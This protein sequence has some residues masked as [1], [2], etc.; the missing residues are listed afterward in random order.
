MGA[1]LLVSNALG[2]G[3]G[4][5]GRTEIWA[6]VIG[7]AGNPLI[8]TGFESFWIS[9]NVQKVWRS[10]SG[11]WDPKGLNEAHNGYLEV[12]LNLG[13]IG[14]CLIALI[15]FSGYR[16]A[17]EAFGRDPEFGGL[18]LAYVATATFYSITEAGFRS[19]SPSWFFFLLAV[20]SASGIGA[21]LF[22]GEARDDFGSRGGIAVRKSLSN[23]VTPEKATVS[24]AQRGLARFRVAHEYSLR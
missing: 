1:D 11:W 14:V 3:E 10:L 5:S 20:I 13:W 21:G 16:R 9:P 24:N 19:L 4:L 15:L 17:G 12:Y 2:R 6:A 18:M 22:G 7:A 23:K 8:G